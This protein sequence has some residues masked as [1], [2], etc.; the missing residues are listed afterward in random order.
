[1]ATVCLDNH[2]VS[3]YLASAEYTRVFLSEFGPE[4]EVLLSTIAWFEALT[5]AFRTIMERKGDNIIPLVER[6]VPVARVASDRYSIFDQDERGS[7]G[8]MRQL[9][10]NEELEEKY[11][12]VT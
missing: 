2:F 3:D 1:M 5:P 6:N 9:D 11:F 12:G 8:P 10:G 4:D 7:E